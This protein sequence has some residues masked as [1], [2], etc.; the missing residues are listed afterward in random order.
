[1]PRPHSASTKTD[2]IL[3]L[4]WRSCGRNS[5]SAMAPASPESQAKHWNAVSW[6]SDLLH[7]SRKILHASSGLNSKAHIPIRLS[8]GFSPV[9]TSGWILEEKNHITSKSAH[10]RSLHSQ[11]LASQTVTPAQT[12]LKPYHCAD[13]DVKVGGRTWDLEFLTSPWVISRL[14]KQCFSNRVS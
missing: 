4:N 12:V 13:S 11:C 6:R 9:W 5:Q 3:G 8:I 2:T 14:V 7:E 10:G 1:M